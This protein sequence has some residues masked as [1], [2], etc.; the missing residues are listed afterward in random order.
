MENIIKMPLHS[1][2]SKIVAIIIAVDSNVSESVSQINTN[3]QRIQNHILE[4]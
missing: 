1:R 2:Y 3:C 4:I